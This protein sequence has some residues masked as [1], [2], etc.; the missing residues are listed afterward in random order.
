MPIIQTRLFGTRPE[1]PQIEPAS[2]RASLKEFMWTDSNLWVAEPKL[3][4]AR[5]LMHCGSEENRFTSRHKSTESDK[6]VERTDNFPHLRN[7]VIPDFNGTVL[8]GEIILNDESKVCD[9]MSVVGS[10]PNHAIKYQMIHNWVSYVIFDVLKYK[11]EDVTKLLYHE[12]RKILEDYISEYSKLCIYMVI[13]PMVDTGK[14]YFYEDIITR[15]GEG[16]VLKRVDAHY[17]EQWVKVKRQSTYDVV[18]MGFES[19]TEM[20][21][22]VDGKYSR[23]RLSELG[24]IGSIVFG[25]YNNGILKNLG[26]CSGMDDST[27]EMFSKDPDKYVG[28]VIEIKAQERT[29]S[30]AF[31][32]PTF[33]RL[34]PD[35]NAKSCT[36]RQE[37]T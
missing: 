31:R 37:E 8:D 6:F 22:K 10:T 9:V 20:T 28:S 30:G 24:L 2:I 29:E 1:L 36:F 5:F 17:G 4:G 3:D 19:P 13:I 21:T 15:G 26:S 27:R 14:R 16:I 33:V 35:K 18:I 32:H 34:R 11:G 25:Q 23:S 7:V 12:R